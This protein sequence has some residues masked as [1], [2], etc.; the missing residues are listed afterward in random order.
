MTPRV[1]LVGCG[2]WGR[3]LARN[4]AALGA[5]DTVCDSDPGAVDRVRAAHPH[6]RVASDL[7]AV[8][9]DPTI[10]ACVIATPAATHFALA[11]QVLAAGKDALVEKPLAL[12]VA[13]GEM[14]VALAERERRILMVGHV[15]EF[16]PA[17]EALRGLAASGELGRLQYVY[18][19]RL[20]LGRIRTEENALWSF[21]PHDVHVL[22]RLLG[23]MPVEVAC[24]G[25]SYVS[26]RVPDVTM[27]LLR[28]ASGVRASIFVS[29]LHPFKEQKLVVVGDRQ[30]AVFDDTAPVDKLLR[31]PHRVDWIERMPIANPGEAFAVPLPAVEPLGAECRHFL[32]CVAT[33]VRPRTDGPSAVAVLRVLEG[34]QQSLERGGVPVA[35]GAPV[36]GGVAIHPTA[37]VDPGCE[38]GTGT[39]VWHY[40]HVMPGARIGRGCVLGQ[41]VFVAS[42]VRVGDNVK[43]Q[44]NVSLFEGVVLDDDVF[45]GPSAVFTNVR[46]PRSHVSRREQFAPTRV[47]RGATIG[48]N[49][50]VVCGHDVGRYA[51]V[52]A[53]A[54]VTRDVPAYAL[55]MGSPA[56]VVGWM[57]GCGARL[58][59]GVRAESEE[60]ACPECGESYRR[61]G[62]KLEPREERP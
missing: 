52:A 50:T 15:L 44:N 21:A 57:C 56:R 35:M 11:R 54:V 5:L 2:P 43:L 8:L 17:I 4:F 55:V 61:V 25:G 20:N 51:F 23:E 62:D 45:C 48:A 16:H 6:V 59:L 34:C 18:S 32:E 1:A 40:A 46:T 29:W 39:R 22:L 3:N 49:A 53:G 37:T 41:G 27:S 60:G 24:H 36:P 28:F 26:E 31:Y 30:M 38:I 9:A 12:T 47:G 33:R 19:N 58:P 14:L 13:E 10:A 42:G 7:T